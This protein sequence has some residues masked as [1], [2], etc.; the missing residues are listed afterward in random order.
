L[1]G[2]RLIEMTADLLVTVRE[3]RALLAELEA[4]LNNQEEKNASIVPAHT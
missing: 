1:A 2:P 3:I 4:L